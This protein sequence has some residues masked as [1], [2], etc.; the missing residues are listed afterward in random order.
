MT[1]EKTH[2]AGDDHVTSRGTVKGRHEDPDANVPEGGK[3]PAP[4][5]GPGHAK[6][7]ASRATDEG[8]DRGDGASA[9]TAGKREH[10]QAQAANAGKPQSGHR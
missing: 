3:A 2:H 8:V 10:D 6:A 1:K 4:T 7:S 5:A 9:A